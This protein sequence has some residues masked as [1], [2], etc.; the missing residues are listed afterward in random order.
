ML[1]SDSM[2]FHA[3]STARDLGV[4]CTVFPTANLGL[5][6][7]PL[8]DISHYVNANVIASAIT[9]GGMI[10]VRVWDLWREKRKEKKRGAASQTADAQA[11]DGNSKSL[12]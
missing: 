3:R 7:L 12:P 5:H 4:V 11:A 8:P 9:F 1:L 10:F 2:K 6:L